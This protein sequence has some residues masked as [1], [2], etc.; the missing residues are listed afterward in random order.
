M[1]DMQDKMMA[2]Q[3]ARAQ[4]RAEKAKEA[5]AKVEVEPTG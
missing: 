5:A 3:R 1:I 4:E 2:A